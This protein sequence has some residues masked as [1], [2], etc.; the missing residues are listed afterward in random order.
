MPEKAAIH[1]LQ[2]Q[3]HRYEIRNESKTVSRANKKCLNYLDVILNH[4][5]LRETFAKSRMIIALTIC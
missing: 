3:S 1:I 2:E 5:L 4:D